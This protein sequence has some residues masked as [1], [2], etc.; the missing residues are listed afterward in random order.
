MSDFLTFINT[1]DLDT[2]T[3]IPGITHSVAENII[4]ARPF[5]SVDECLKVKG[6]GKTLLGKLELFAEAQENESENSAMIPVEEEAPPVYIE[7][8]QPAQENVKSR[9]RSCLVWEGRLSTFCALC[10]DWLFSLF[11]SAALARSYI[12]VSLTSTEH[13]FRPWNETPRRSQN[14]RLKFPRCKRNWMK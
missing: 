12:M 4:T 2:L 11:L 3:R 1:A 14:L 8:S 13:S 5:N 7:K 6:M 10:F 9:I